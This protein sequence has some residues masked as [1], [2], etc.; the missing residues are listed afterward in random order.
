MTNAA[1]TLS[2][3]IA[4]LLR[5]GLYTEM[6][7][8]CAEAPATGPGSATRSGW[9]VVLRRI[10]AAARGL[11]LIGW[12]DPED[13][14]PMTIT[15][16][17]TM[18]SALAAEADRWRRASEQTRTE[19]ADRRIRAA[20]NAAAIEQFLTCLGERPARLM[21]PMAAMPLVRECAHE[22]VPMVSEAID[23][24]GLD[25]RECGRRLTALCDFL[26]LIGWSEDEEPSEAVDA[27]AHARV[28]REVA[29]SMLQTLATAVSEAV[30]DP[31]ERVKAAG[32]LCLLTQLDKR[33]CEL[34]GG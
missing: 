27:T 15:L 25:L 11:D 29:A 7:R 8:A 16:D 6:Q 18:I 12:A 4:L 20:G 32:E 30:D 9:T 10:N 3:Q 28:M 1:A 14:E 33:A 19:S 13:R 17:A 34:L 21:I 2:P 5:G 31:G 26:D 23:S 24:T 22:G